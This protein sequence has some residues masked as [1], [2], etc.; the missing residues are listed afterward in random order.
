M[1]VKYQTLISLDKVSIPFHG[2]SELQLES[3]GLDLFLFL[4]PVESPGAS[5]AV[6]KLTYAALEA[7][8]SL[9][10]AFLGLEFSCQVLL[11]MTPDFPVYLGGYNQLFLTAERVSHSCF[12]THL[13]SFL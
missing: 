6:D 8:V 2:P 4:F 13:P 10:S 5:G 11:E 7:S 1:L 12:H 9:S 3:Q